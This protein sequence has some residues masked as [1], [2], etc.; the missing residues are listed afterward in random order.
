MRSAVS[1]ELITVIVVMGLGVLAM[2][3]LQPILPLYLTSIGIVPEVL[4]LMFSVAMVGMVVGE[5]AWGWVADRRGLKLPLTMGTAVCGVI[6]LGYVFLDST[7]VI[8]AVFFLWGIARSALFGPGRGYIGATAPPLRKAT[9]M[10]IISVM[11][12]AS[13][14][15][16]AL[17]SGFMAEAWGYHSVFYVSCG[18]AL[19]GGL[20]VLAGLKRAQPAG[21]ERLLAAAPPGRSLLKTIATIYRPL[22]AQCVVATLQFVGLGITIT[23]LPLL[24]T[25][26][27][28]V[29]PREVGILF[30]VG[31]IAT[32]VLGIPMGM[33]ADRVGKKTFMVLGMLVSAATMAGTAFVESYSLLVFLVVARSLGMAMFNPAALGLLSDS[34]PLERQSTVMGVYGGVCENTGIVAGSA[35]GGLVWSALGARAAFLTGTAASCLAVT[36][37]LFLVKGQPRGIPN[38]A[39]F[40]DD[41]RY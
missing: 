3:V 20:A 2:S 21:R 10:A 38:L 37:C 5:S 35:L 1:R 23:F 31:G 39:S 32:V 30:T 14:S 4:G 15:L 11:M 29:S 9:F 25:Q 24:A 17:P 36:V 16:G 33:L 41:R 40:D 28:G 22:S 27:V 13:R 18:I 34:I 12:A 26:V 19:A 6:V 7:P 8:F